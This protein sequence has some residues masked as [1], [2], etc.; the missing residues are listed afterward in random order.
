MVCRGAQVPEQWKRSP[1]VTIGDAELE[2]PGPVADVLAGHWLRR[3]PVVVALGVDARL[4]REPEVE[5]REPWLLGPSHDLA[6][7]R[8]QFMLWR[9]NYDA[10]SGEPRWWWAERARRLGATIGGPADVVL[11]SGS[12]AWC[13]GGPHQ[14][15]RGLGEG[16]VVVHAESV[17]RDR[18]GVVGDIPTREDLADDQR[19]AVEH[20]RG[21]ARVLA[22]AGSGKTRVLTAR[23]RHLLADR[24][25]ERDSLLAVA[26]NKR[27]ADELVERTAGLRAHVRTLN[28]LGLALCNGSGGFSLPPG[29]KRRR[30]LDEMEVRRLLSEIL[31][32]PYARNTDPLAPYLEALGAI[33]LGL[34]D[35]GE[36]E[37]S[38]ELPGLADG[39]SAYQRALDRLGALDFDQQV[40]E[41]IRLLLREPESRARAQ[42]RARHLL[43]DE[44]QDLTPAH[45]LLLRLIAA[46][47]FDV[48][49]VG[50][51][52]Q[53][54][55][56]YAG[57][58][59][60]FLIHYGDYFPGA[61]GH[62]LGVNYRCPP[63]AIAASQR[64]LAR[65]RERLGARVRP[66]PGR[67]PSAGELTV[68]RLPAAP[69]TPAVAERI[70]GWLSSGKA[71]RDVAVLARVSAALLALQVTLTERGI[72]CR[73]L[74]DAGILRRTGSRAALSY[75]RLATRPEQLEV[76][77][78]EEALRRPARRI[79]RNVAERLLG[80]STT[81]LGGLRRLECRLHGSDASKVGTLI[82]DIDRLARVA[83]AG[84]TL[85]VLR[86]VRLDLGLG[87]SMERLDGS[88]GEADRSS[89]LDD[90]LALEHVAGLH[91]DPA[92][93][94]AWLVAL[95]GRRSDCG[96]EL[97]TIH[98]V[99]GREWDQVVVIGLNAGLLP[100]RLASDVEEERRVLH[101]GM[102][103]ARRQ[104]VVV[105]DSEQPSPFL[106]ELETDPAPMAAGVRARSAAGRSGSHSR[107]PRAEASR[108]GH[109]TA[110]RPSSERAAADCGGRA[111]EERLS[112]LL[113]AWRASTAKAG[114]VP[115][116][117][118][119]HDRHLQLLAEARP[120]SLAALGR[121][122]GMGPLR[123]ERYGTELLAVIASAAG[124]DDRHAASPDA[125]L[126]PPVSA[127][128]A[129]QRPN[130]GT[131]LG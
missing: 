106:D 81:S 103:R 114:G 85:S 121:C 117:V 44:V 86:T 91:P 13:D 1:V 41:A 14:P 87:S 19:A 31:S 127:D 76:A 77:D 108:A 120:S 59:P 18:L 42:L 65:N 69:S 63:A 64:L 40:L 11:E 3:E 100:H 67:E 130:A 84:T 74:L 90:L 104:L 22:P 96:V 105:G 55:Y 88:H 123:L 7:E 119:L 27:A 46:P 102:T 99:K 48:F 6:R 34:R 92:T 125:P 53:V 70:E 45:V 57:A 24:A 47:G 71:P 52:D 12:P 10:R 49:G 15:L 37:R 118:V 98:R 2:R 51:D 35:P 124:D 17:E 62:T 115:A 58:S 75:L 25:V 73:S 101:V 97:S 4:V 28:A 60:R 43:V 56:G 16:V 61:T 5:G 89:H 129:E 30:V 72:P 23:L 8:L 95:L 80:Q 32:L 79:A 82:G 111:P 9:N 38:W 66:S 122:P 107:R 39:F 94:E 29:R 50:D 26:F 33:R 126:S 68:L 20:L 131:D 113:R 128:A 83:S 21:P 78:L 109:L 110:D 54:I 116:Y 93:F 112:Q 36:V